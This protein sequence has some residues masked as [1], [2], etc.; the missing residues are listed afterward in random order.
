MK[1]IVLFELDNRYFPVFFGRGCEPVT[2]QTDV[3]ARDGSHKTSGEL[4]AFVFFKYNRVPYRER[5][6]NI[7]I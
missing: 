6:R 7:F 1:E 3:V 4:L 2:I 5:D